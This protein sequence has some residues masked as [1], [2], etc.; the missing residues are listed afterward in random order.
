MLIDKVTDEHTLQRRIMAKEET[1]KEIEG[2]WADE[3]SLERLKLQNNGI[4]IT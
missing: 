2:K 3:D 1:F 4:D